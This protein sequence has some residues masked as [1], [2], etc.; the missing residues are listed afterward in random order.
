MINLT[1]G[2]SIVDGPGQNNF[3][4]AAN[5]WLGDGNYPFVFPEPILFQNDSKILLN[6]TDLSGVD[7]VIDLALHGTLIKTRMWG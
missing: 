7:N 3:E 5:L 4:L 2:K 6:L 1:T